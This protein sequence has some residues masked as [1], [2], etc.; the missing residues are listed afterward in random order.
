M[1]PEIL[2]A[3]ASQTAAATLSTAAIV[4]NESTAICCLHTVPCKMLPAFSVSKHL[5]MLGTACTLRIL[6]H[7]GAVLP[8]DLLHACNVR[9]L[10][11][12][13]TNLL[14]G[15]VTTWTAQV[16]PAC[17]LKCHFDT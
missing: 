13:Y 8:K 5:Q 16:Q 4:P 15:S 7:H 14:A 1:R 11:M 12:A 3:S 17:L 9:C 6:S 2:H 10:D